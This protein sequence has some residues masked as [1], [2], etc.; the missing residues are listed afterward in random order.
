MV[1][2]HVR[3]HVSS[4]VCPGRPGSSWTLS[5]FLSGVFSIS[6]SPQTKPTHIK[7]LP[8]HDIFLS[9]P[10]QCFSHCSLLWNAHPPRLALH[11]HFT[12]FFE[13]C[14]WCAQGSFPWSSC[15]IRVHLFSALLH[16]ITII[17]LIALH[18]GFFV[19]FPTMYWAPY[20]QDLILSIFVTPVPSTGLSKH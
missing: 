12:S 15:R 5:L 20:S 18:D 10:L 2:H 16:L 14:L 1:P 7:F 9:R 3:I 19:S 6:H 17:T 11:V 8:E 4:L 13:I